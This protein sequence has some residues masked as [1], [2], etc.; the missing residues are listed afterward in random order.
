MKISIKLYQADLFSINL[1]RLKKNYT[2]TNISKELILHSLFNKKD[3]VKDKDH[4]N[5]NPVG[6]KSINK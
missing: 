2:K 3:R 6:K 5:Q 1:L 4:L